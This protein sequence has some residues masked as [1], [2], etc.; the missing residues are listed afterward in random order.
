MRENQRNLS[1]DVLVYLF[2][3]TALVIAKELEILSIAAQHICLYPSIQQDDEL[4][5]CAVSEYT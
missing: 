3:Q 4:L 2:I 5:K 1:C